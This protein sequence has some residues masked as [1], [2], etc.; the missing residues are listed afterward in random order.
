MGKPA[1]N[2]SDGRPR[3][4]DAFR[5]L[6]LASERDVRAFIAAWGIPG[7]AVDDLAQET[8]LR[9]YQQSERRPGDVAEVAWLRGSPEICVVI[10]SGPSNNMDG[11]W[12]FSARCWNR[13]GD[14]ISKVNS[15]TIGNWPAC[16]PA[17]SC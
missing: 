3:D 12:P 14:R 15:T 4:L 2:S 7:C 17:L 13:A 16:G 5:E 11:I 8:Y 1:G 6:I 10:M 9:Y